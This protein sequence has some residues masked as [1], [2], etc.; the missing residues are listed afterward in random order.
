MIRYMG[1][2]S[3]GGDKIADIINSLISEEYPNY[4]EPF[5][6]GGS[7]IRRI[8]NGKIKYATDN[9][10]YLINLFK[11]IQNGWLPEEKITE[12]KYKQIM[13][14]KELKP[15][16]AFCGFCLSWGG[17]WF[18]GIARDKTNKRNFQEEQTKSIL[19]YRENIKDVIFNTKDFLNSD[20]SKVKNYV[21]Y[22]D[23]PYENTTKYKDK[24]NHES[25]WNKCK[26][27]SKNNIVLVSEY[28]EPKNCNFETLLTFKKTKSL[29]GNIEGKAETSTEKLFLIKE[30]TND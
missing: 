25:F 27:L 11:N 4:W 12:E 1:G 14:E 2:K 26:E 29:R 30:V 28:S 17:K 15:I 20:I 8:W 6:G 13:K 7:I 21:I 10:K 22:C 18:G 24:F 5:V 3:K 9:N 23:P 19:K 16:T